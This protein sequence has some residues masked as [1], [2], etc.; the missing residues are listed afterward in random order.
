MKRKHIQ[1]V[2]R[3]KDVTQPPPLPQ[4][5]PQSQPQS[6]AKAKLPS[7]PVKRI[8]L[9]KKDHPD[10]H[11]GDSNPA[12]PANTVEVNQ[13]DDKEEI[14]HHLDLQETK[15][16]DS[17]H[18]PSLVD[19]LEQDDDDQSG[20]EDN[21][22]FHSHSDSDS[23]G[24]DNIIHPVSTTG[25]CGDDLHW[26]QLH[27]V[28]VIKSIKS[29]RPP[30]D[31]V[32]D[33]LDFSIQLVG[34]SQASAFN[35][36]EMKQCLDLDYK[37]YTVS[38]TTTLQIQLTTSSRVLLS[39]LL[40][41]HRGLGEYLHR[42]TW[43]N[44]SLPAVRDDH[45]RQL[46]LWKE[47]HK[48]ES[49]DDEC[50]DEIGVKEEIIKRFYLMKASTHELWSSSPDLL[51]GESGPEYPNQDNIF[52]WMQLIELQQVKDGNLSPTFASQVFRCYTKYM[53][54]VMNKP[55][56]KHQELALLFYFMFMSKA[57][58]SIIMI[59]YGP[60]IGDLLNIKTSKSNKE[61][62]DRAWKKWLSSFV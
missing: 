26:N 45:D 7:L 20:G 2:L 41:N 34:T 22:N 55:L 61:V 29:K 43:K 40:C 36:V 32:D 25:S 12:N 13:D 37:S 53:Q 54:V 33:I 38:S 59:M 60:I 48:F 19:L 9:I 57:P 4:P 3:A 39:T 5:L 15:E 42:A 62:Q 50:H 49:F 31:H 21:S 58:Q 46:D 14:I 8:K 6:K 52:H 17:Q 44:S 30:R 18:D 56:M 11:K 28:E 23:D 47:Q 27:S 24:D 35:N 16:S 1:V 51:I 10:Y